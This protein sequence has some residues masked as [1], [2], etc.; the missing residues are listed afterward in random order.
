MNVWLDAPSK[1]LQKI[2]KVFFERHSTFK[3]RF[4]EIRTAPFSDVFRC[5]GE[6]TMKAEIY[7]KDGQVLKRQL[8]L[9]LQQE[10]VAVQET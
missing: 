6:F 4:S 10:D 1:F 3:N 9:T 8:Y 2:D 7:L 5:W